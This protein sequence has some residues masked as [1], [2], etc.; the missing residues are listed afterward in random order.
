MR[1]GVSVALLKKNACGATFK[2]KMVDL[3]CLEKYAGN[4]KGFDNPGCYV[5]QNPRI[6]LRHQTPV[7]FLREKDI[8]LCSDFISP[9]HYTF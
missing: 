7:G 3:R 5:V 9:S 4:T 8:F 2:W 6:Y 1:A